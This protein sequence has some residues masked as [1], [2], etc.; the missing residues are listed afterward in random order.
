M[1]QP[2]FGLAEYSRATDFWLGLLVLV[3]I[4][5]TL[6]DFDPTGDNSCVSLQRLNVYYTYFQPNWPRVQWCTIYCILNLYT[7]F[8][9]VSLFLTLLLLSTWAPPLLHLK[10][11]Q[12]QVKV[13]GMSVDC[14]PFFCISFWVNYHTRS[15]SSLKLD[16]DLI[17]K[18][19]KN[20]LLVHWQWYIFQYFHYFWSF[21]FKCQMVLKSHWHFD[22]IWWALY[23]L[24]R[25]I[26]AYMNTSK[27]WN[28]IILHITKFHC[29]R[30]SVL[31]KV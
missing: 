29:T 15:K 25:L 10:K 11:L 27:V 17:N 7:T 13:N 22:P 28:F 5:N 1:W 14:K 3:G 2:R 20:W 6:V 8:F 26:S 9:F 30:K 23:A 4:S 19:K 18:L 21:S 31:S 12:I 24:V 16:Q